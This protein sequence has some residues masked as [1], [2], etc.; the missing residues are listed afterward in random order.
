MEVCPNKAIEIHW[1]E[2]TQ[3]DSSHKIPTW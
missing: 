2:G 1:L 3:S